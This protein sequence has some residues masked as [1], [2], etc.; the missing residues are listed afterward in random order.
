MKKAYEA[1]KSGK[2]KGG[3]FSSW[4]THGPVIVNVLAEYD[5]QPNRAKLN[6]DYTR[7]TQA[8]ASQ[9]IS[10]SIGQIVGEST[11]NSWLKR[12]RKN[13]GKIFG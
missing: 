4:A 5:S 6:T 9:K 12:Y 13:D 1:E 2:I 7:L 8:K 11:F 3:K 10:S